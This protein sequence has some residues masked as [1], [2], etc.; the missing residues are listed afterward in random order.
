MLD[1]GNVFAPVDGTVSKMTALS[2]KKLPKAR[3]QAWIQRLYRQKATMVQDL[4]QHFQP[5]TSVFV[6]VGEPGWEHL[7]K[8]MC[9]RG[10]A[11]GMIPKPYNAVGVRRMLKEHYKVC[12]S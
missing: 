4:K 2:F 5:D 1:L 7:L 11:Q 10:V 8:E 9:V 6:T 3:Q 12:K